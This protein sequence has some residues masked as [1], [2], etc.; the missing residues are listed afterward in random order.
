MHTFI[1]HPQ[2]RPFGR[3]AFILLF[4]VTAAMFTP[5][6]MATD[7][8]LDEGPL[9]PA[10]V[11]N[12]NTATAD[13]LCWLP[14]IG[15]GKALRIVDYRNTRPFKRVVELARVKGIGL[16]TVRRLRPWIVVDGPSTLNGPIRPQGHDG[17]SR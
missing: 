2:T 7:T 12:L 15:K 5:R 11:L 9:P 10:G 8:V 16:K 1:P 13:Q 3:V 6:A 4:A 14:G 17:T